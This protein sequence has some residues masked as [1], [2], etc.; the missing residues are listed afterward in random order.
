MAA[1]ALDGLLPAG[2]FAARERSPRRGGAAHTAVARDPLSAQALFTLSTVQQATGG[3][4]ALARATLQRAVRLQPSNPQTW[5]TLGEYDLPAAIEIAG[6][7][8]AA[9]ALNELARPST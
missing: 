6:A 4:A 8:E 9:S 1:P 2:A 3:T 5:L 7:A